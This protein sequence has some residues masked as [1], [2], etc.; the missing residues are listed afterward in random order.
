MWFSDSTHSCLERVTCAQAV[1]PPQFTTVGSYVV[2]PNDGYGWLGC[3]MVV[4]AE[5]GSVTVRFLHPH[6]PS[7][8]FSFHEPPDMLEVD[9]SD[10]APRDSNRHFD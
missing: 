7:S 3:T 6:L 10:I 9:S 2:V 1:V 4:D 8:S 5:A